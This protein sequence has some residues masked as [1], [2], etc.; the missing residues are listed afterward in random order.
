M[1][2]TIVIKSKKFTFTYTKA[3]LNQNILEFNIKILLLCKVNFH[4][5]KMLKINFIVME[6][7]IF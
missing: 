5:V 4:N 7:R 1:F 3:I 6:K 2:F